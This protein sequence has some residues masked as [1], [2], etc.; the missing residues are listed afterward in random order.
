MDIVKSII[1]SILAFQEKILRARLGRTLGIKNNSKRK[2]IFQND[3]ILSIEAVAD[4]EK[5][6]LEEELKLILKQANYEPEKLLEYIKSQGT[7]VYYID[8]PKLLYSIGENEGFIYPQTGARAIYLSLLT[9]NKWKWK[10]DEM[11]ITSKGEINKF[12]FIYHVYNWFSYEH[13]LSGVDAETVKLLNK[14]LFC[15]KEEDFKKLQLKE[16]YDLKDAIK[17]DKASINFVLKLCSEIEGAQKAFQKLQ[18]D[19]AN[20]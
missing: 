20:I 8:N 11:F 7:S 9:T 14:Y 19:G 13:G 4:E 1:Y 15:A 17:Q 10:T 6:K 5:N 16:I 3:C 18:D 2:Q 12:Y